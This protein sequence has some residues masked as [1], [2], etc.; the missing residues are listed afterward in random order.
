ASTA[1]AVRRRG[2]AARDRGDRRAT[3]GRPRRRRDHGAARAV[4]SAPRLRPVHERRGRPSSSRDHRSRE[5]PFVV[6]TAA[7]RVLP[8][9]EPRTVSPSLSFRVV[10]LRHRGWRA[11]GACSRRAGT[12]KRMSTVRRTFT[13]TAVAILTI[14]GALALWKLRELVALLF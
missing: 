5:V 2:G 13:I 4:P 9:L 3:A 12:R 8:V 14:A 7:G 10:V 1:R 6:L 11:A